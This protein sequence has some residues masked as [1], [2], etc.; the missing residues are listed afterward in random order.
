MA[1]L[2][3]SSRAISPV[4]GQTHLEFE[5]TLPENNDPGGESDDPDRPSR[6]ASTARI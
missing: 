6:L 3:H 4:K 1:L 5:Q 2:R